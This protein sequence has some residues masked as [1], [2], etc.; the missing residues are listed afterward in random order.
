MLI[1][2]LQQCYSGLVTNLCV[3]DFHLLIYSTNVSFG[4]SALLC[5]F[6]SVISLSNVSVIRLLRVQINSSSMCWI[7]SSRGSIS[8]SSYQA[9]TVERYASL[10]LL[11]GSP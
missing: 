5:L 11:F 6:T 9:G 3:V 4:P 2:H 10:S 8:S 1:D 7:R